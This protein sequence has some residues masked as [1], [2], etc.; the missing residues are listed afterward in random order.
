MGIY[1]N[2]RTSISD[3]EKEDTKKFIDNHKCKDPR[4]VGFGGKIQYVDFIVGTC[5]IGD[6]I[7]IRCPFCKEELDITDVGAW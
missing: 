1:Y 6:C 3:K 5:S 7:D 2:V 4:V